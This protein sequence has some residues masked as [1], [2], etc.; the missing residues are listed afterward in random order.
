MEKVCPERSGVYDRT[1][2]Y[3]SFKNDNDRI[4]TLTT[5]ADSSSNRGNRYNKGE[6]GRLE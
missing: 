1:A 2:V 4:A 3:I 5:L 6:S